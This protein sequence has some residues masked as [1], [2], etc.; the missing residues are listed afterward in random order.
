[1]VGSNILLQIPTSFNEFQEK[2]GYKK[3][4]IPLMISI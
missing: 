1:M 4:N 2:F 3:K